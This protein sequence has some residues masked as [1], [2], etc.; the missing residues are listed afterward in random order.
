M[1]R[2]R[3]DERR[4]KK[5]EK[6]K[7]TIQKIRK[8]RSEQGALQ[9]RESES[10]IRLALGGKTF[11]YTELKKTS[12][13]SNNKTFRT[14]LN[15]MVERE[16]ITKLTGRKGYML[17]KIRNYES[18]EF[19]AIEIL[20]AFL[21]EQRPINEFNQ[22]VGSFVAYTLKSYELPQATQIIT[23]VLTQVGFTSPP[24]NIDQH[25]LLFGTP[26]IPRF[27]AESPEWALWRAIDSR[28]YIASEKIAKES[29][30]EKS[31]TKLPC[32]GKCVCKKVSDGCMN[33]LIEAQLKDKNV[34]PLKTQ[35]IERE[36]FDF[37]KFQ[38]EWVQQPSLQLNE[39][40][41]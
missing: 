40:L 7:I 16:E 4:K 23:T 8:K 34:V 39:K 32:S 19:F 27:Q 13:L 3:E 31:Q 9:V 20:S 33:R 6:K 36:Y 17:T 38:K 10:K 14:R 26:A 41:E 18:L 24:P 37:K 22:Q 21:K 25:L 1:P 12:G 15:A 2:P 5:A 30:P 28:E 29:K 35:I 11:S